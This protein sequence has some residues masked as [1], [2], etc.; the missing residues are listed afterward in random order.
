MNDAKNQ[1]AMAKQIPQMGMGCQTN[2]KR[3][4]IYLFLCLAFVSAVLIAPGQSN[5]A[6]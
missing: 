6:G 4:E 5:V 3:A 2:H 1:A